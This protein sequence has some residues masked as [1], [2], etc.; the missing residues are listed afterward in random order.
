M[1]STSL[2]IFIIDVQW[3]LAS[4]AKTSV[5][6]RDLLQNIYFFPMLLLG[7]LC[8]HFMFSRWKKVEAGNAFSSFFYS[9]IFIA[10][11]VII[12]IT[13]IAKLYEL[14]MKTLRTIHEE[15]LA[16][17]IYSK[18]GIYSVL[19]ASI[20]FVDYFLYKKFPMR[21]ILI[22]V[23]GVFILS[24]PLYAG[25]D[26]SSLPVKNIVIRVAIFF[27]AFPVLVVG[28]LPLRILRRV[29]EKSEVR[30]HT[31]RKDAKRHLTSYLLFIL[32][33]LAFWLTAYQ[34]NVGA[35][36]MTLYLI[37]FL[38]STITVMKLVKKEVPSGGD[39]I[40][41]LV[42]LLFFCN[43]LFFMITPISQ[44]QV[45]EKRL[46]FAIHYLSVVFF[47]IATLVAFFNS[48]VAWISLYDFRDYTKNL[49]STLPQKVMDEKRTSGLSDSS[50]VWSRS[51][52]KVEK[53]K[54]KVFT[55]FKSI[56][57]FVTILAFV[58]QLTFPQMA[59]GLSYS[60]GVFLL[61]LAY[62]V[63]SEIVFKVEILFVS[64]WKAE[65]AGM[66]LMADNICDADVSKWV[67]LFEA[68]GVER[69]RIYGVLYENGDGTV[70][71]NFKALVRKSINESYFA[72]L[73][74]K[75]TSLFAVNHTPLSPESFVTRKDELLNNDS[76][77]L[78]ARLRWYNSGN[79]VFTFIRA[80]FLLPWQKE[81][82]V[83]FDQLGQINNLWLKRAEII[84][85]APIHS[86]FIT[87]DIS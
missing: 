73:K 23:S 12:Y 80:F 67:R 75:M 38:L 58:V 59:V 35:W 51:V 76:Y 68:H 85:N 20:G 11:M 65:F 31:K 70:C 74:E 46:H 15:F 62:Y 52:W 5:P 9:G 48:A 56:L 26:G 30:K 13:V 14:E 3:L 53:A 60:I 1:G 81:L 21:A 45:D 39:I 27:V 17:T 55:A 24:L 36:Q 78:A 71:E 61:L 42:A 28:L 34:F 77:V 40:I 54:G 8:I 18:Y 2:N 63:L 22:M 49:P 16:A 83:M 84:S 19:L 7:I 10:F 86:S 32:I 33:G 79:I 43:Y 57:I 82:L 37:T 64:S 6:S 69:N 50:L 47:V 72:L 44:F 25:T 66:H 29:V 41:S 87:E 4:E